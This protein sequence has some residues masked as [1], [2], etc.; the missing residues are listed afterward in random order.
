MEEARERGIPMLH[1][2]PIQFPK[3]PDAA[4]VSDEFM[5]GDE[6][7]VAPLVDD[8]TSRDV[9]FPMGIW[10]RLS[11][12]RVF[13][14]RKTVTIEGDEL[15]LFA[16]NGAVLPLG[17]NP[18]KLHYFPRLGGEFFIF[19]S[20]LGEYSQV[21]AGPAGD[22]MR[23]EMESKKDRDYEWIVHHLDR[24]REITAGETTYS[25]VGSRERLRP[26]SWFYDAANQN[27]H[28]R[29]LAGAN[30]DVIINIAF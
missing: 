2:L 9:Y 14:G 3:D 20:D 25:S 4:K 26:G 8:Q 10:T 7:L 21:H 5:L 27:L 28:V 18:M 6:L 23:L 13:Q 30:A 22:F 1:P 12:N 24:P 19:E 16:R 29:A 17:S 11:D 15:P